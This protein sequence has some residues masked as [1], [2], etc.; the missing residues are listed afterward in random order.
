MQCPYCNADSNV[1]D[2]RS[3]GDAVRRRRVCGQCKRR[4]TTYER[5]APPNVKVIKRSGK[6]EPFDAAK[7]RAVLARVGAGRPAIDGAAIKRLAAAIEAELVDDRVKTVS[8]AT[9][10]ERLLARLEDLDKLA[11]ERLAADYLDESGQLRVKPQPGADDDQL[12][13]FEE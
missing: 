1:V 5:V 10:A 13:L 12:G 9:L 8:S 7:I 11:Y 6:A 2:S 3:L 4:F